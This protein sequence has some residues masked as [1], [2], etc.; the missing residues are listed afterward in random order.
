MSESTSP[1]AAVRDTDRGAADDLELAYRRAVALHDE[2][3]AP[4]STVRANVLAAA[5]DAALQASAASAVAM[6]SMPAGRPGEGAM[7]R[8]GAGRPQAANRS[9]WRLRAGA[10]TCVAL[11]VAGL[12][13]WRIEEQRS[14]GLGDTVVALATSSDARVPLAA[15]E[16]A[17]PAVRALP[18]P[19][20]A[21]P[22]PP[23]P[24]VL[25]DAA[26]VLSSPRDGG[27]AA[28]AQR[29]VPA[30]QLPSKP[31]VEDAARL[32]AARVDGAAR[33]ATV[34]AQAAASAPALSPSI[35]A[36][37]KQAIAQPLD[38][39]VPVA[40]SRAAAPAAVAVAAAHAPLL[41]PA[42]PS[43]TLVELS[44]QSVTPGAPSAPSA[45]LS[46]GAV[47]VHIAPSLQRWADAGDVAAISR[48][49]AAPGHAVDAPD[50]RGRTALLHAV[51]AGQ[52]AAVRALLAAGADPMRADA[53]GLTPRDAARYSA[54]AEI[55][56]LLDGGAR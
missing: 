45:P 16:R 22:T 33:G 52:P 4:A 10:T 14:K 48:W 55:E 32:D 36:S 21:L 46:V 19:V 20:P 17:A 26:P 2:G 35:V 47:S 1:G 34:V 44:G 42:A 15:V 12:V 28:F 24:E 3:R 11:L 8:P 5:R 39:R 56:A 43:A 40:L 13:G 51:M 9:A 6:A 18:A 53:Q 41:S 30:R 37:S 50:V 54:N 31:A 29:A 38:S 27:V 7:A 25:A 49:L 23:P